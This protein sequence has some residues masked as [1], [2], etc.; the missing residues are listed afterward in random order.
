M[1]T[2]IYQSNIIHDIEMTLRCVLTDGLYLYA[3]FRAMPYSKSSRTFLECKGISVLEWPGNSPDINPIEN[4]WNI[5]KKVIGNQFPCKREEMWDRV[6]DAW[7]SVA[8]SV[9]EELYNSMPRKIADLYKTKG[10]ATKYLFMM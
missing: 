5:I 10:H 2:W 4:V 9:L 8:T 1:V 3:C 7:Y 6:C